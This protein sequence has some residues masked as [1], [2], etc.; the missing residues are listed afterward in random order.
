MLGGGEVVCFLSI[1]ALLQSE[2]EVYL[3]SHSLPSSMV[4]DTMEACHATA[5]SR[6]EMPVFRAPFRQGFSSAA[7]MKGR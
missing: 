5:A 7:R 2:H 1:R 4:R 3:A 6:L